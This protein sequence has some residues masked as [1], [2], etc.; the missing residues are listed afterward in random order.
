METD[1][2][3]RENRTLA[4]INDDVTNVTIQ[5]KISF[6]T[7]SAH[8]P[9]GNRRGVERREENHFKFLVLQPGEMYSPS[10]LEVL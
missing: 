10:V 1:G 6:R 5:V 9:P 2:S 8:A 3:S 4:N 7:L